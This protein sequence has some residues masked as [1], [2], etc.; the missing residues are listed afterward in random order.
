MIKGEKFEIIIQ[1]ELKCEGDKSLWLFLI[2]YK[3]DIFLAIHFI[4]ASLVYLPIKDFS[5]AN[6]ILEKLYSKLSGLKSNISLKGLLLRAF[7]FKSIYQT[8]FFI[9]LFGIKRI[10]PYY[11]S[12]LT[13]RYNIKG[14]SFFTFNFDNDIEDSIIEIRLPPSNEI[15][16]HFISHQNENYFRFKM[17]RKFKRVLRA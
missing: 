14:D 7:R 6:I 12:V 1:K 9:N 8:L 17:H 11:I 15:F 4:Q 3:Q 5:A 2:G 13:K 16:G 10:H